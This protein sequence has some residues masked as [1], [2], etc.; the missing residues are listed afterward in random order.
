MTTREPNS[1]LQ[2]DRDVFP[3]ELEEIERR[4]ALLDLPPTTPVETEGVSTHRKLTGLAISGGGIRSAAFALGAL[5]KMAADGVFRGFDYLSTVSGGGYIGSAVSS[6]L[7]AGRASHAK[8]EFPFSHTATRS[9]ERVGLLHLRRFSNYLFASGVSRLRILLM[10]M[11]GLVVNLFL[12]L[13]PM[14]VAVALTQ[15]AY[16]LVGSTIAFTAQVLIFGGMAA[17][18]AMVLHPVVL[19][20]GAGRFDW[21]RRERFEQAVTGLAAFLLVPLTLWPLLLAA[22]WSAA[23]SWRD[24]F[25]LWQAYEERIH[26]AGAVIGGTLF[27]GVV[28]ASLTRSKRLRALVDRMVLMLVGIMLPTV[29][30]LI[31]LAMC[32]TVINMHTFKAEIPLW[33]ATRADVEKALMD[34]DIDLQGMRYE[35]VK[36]CVTQEWLV[37]IRPRLDGPCWHA[38]KENGQSWTIFT[39]S[40]SR[41]AVV[42][43]GGFTRWPELWWLLLA[44]GLML[45][46]RIFIDINHTAIHGFYRDRLSRAFMLRPGGQRGIEHADNLKLHEMNA[47]GVAP[48][49]LLNAAINLAGSTNSQARGRGADFFQFAKH[50]CGGPSTGYVATTA[51]EAVH[52]HLNVG[53]AMAISGA[54]AA[55]NMGGY[56]VSQLSPW[57]AILNFRLGYWL[58]NPSYVRSQH[59]LHRLQLR[60]GV[61]PRYLMREALSQPNATTPFVNLS[62]GGHIEN[63]GAY[64]LLRRRCAL[65]VMIDAEADPL[66]QFP[67][68]TALERL[69]R[70]DLGVEI[71]LDPESLAPDASG[72]SA[73]HVMVGSFRYADGEKGVMLY[74]RA[75]MTGDEAHGTRAYRARSTTFPHESTADQFFSEEQFEAYRALGEHAAAELTPRWNELQP[76]AVVR[77]KPKAQE[78]ADQPALPDLEGKFDPAD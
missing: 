69:A 27:V 9:G 17:I 47:S 33:G 19:R 72:K 60:M 22:H 68:L 15:L 63:L 66:A 53:T 12:V 62:D 75:N 46:N 48:Y 56:T 65:I 7:G 26:M 64:E 37:R 18:F 38:T 49:H 21:Q 59:W 23:H 44:A 54:A 35:W 57:M 29:G 1:E 5:Q 76:N 14:L 24:F 70:I 67:G 6:M 77:P 40:E 36:P 11:R 30:V 50:H 32:L 73:S 8:E 39:E 45:F 51:L 28:A 25:E 74:L 52:P 31:Y 78:S 42:G 61:P 2:F 41:L 4:R 55:P 43:G 13:P 71:T 34:A 16:K 20:V 10:L 58:P 3:A